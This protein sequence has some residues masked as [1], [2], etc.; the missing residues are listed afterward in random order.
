MKNSLNHVHKNEFIKG[1]Q[2]S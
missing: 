2:F 1:I